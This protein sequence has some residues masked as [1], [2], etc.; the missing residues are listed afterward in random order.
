MEVAIQVSTTHLHTKLP[1]GLAVVLIT[2]ITIAT[3]MIQQSFS[4]TLITMVEGI[5]SMEHW[6]GLAITMFLCEI[7]LIV[8]CS[9]FSSC[10]SS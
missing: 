8:L 4:T 10:S 7:R 5:G 1:M 6:I 2:M 3:V 9:S